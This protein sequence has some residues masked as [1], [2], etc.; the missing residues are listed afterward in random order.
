MTVEEAKG[1]CKDR[2]KSKDVI[3]APKG[4]GRDLMRVCIECY[5]FYFINI[6]DTHT[7]D[8]LQSKNV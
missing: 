6:L 7:H 8:Y 4:N 3:S 1:V 5:F 2:S